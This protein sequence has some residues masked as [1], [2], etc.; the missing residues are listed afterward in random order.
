[1]PVSSSPGRPTSRSISSSG[2]R[3]EMLAVAGQREGPGGRAARTPVEGG[4]G[5]VERA[6]CPRLRSRV[7]IRVRRSGD[8]AP[9]R[10][11][12]VLRAWT[13]TRGGHPGDP[14]LGEAHR[15]ARAWHRVVGRS[16]RTRS[17]VI[18]SVVKVRAGKVTTWP[19]GVTARPARGPPETGCPPS[20]V[21]VTRVIDRSGSPVWGWIE[22]Q[23]ALG[24]GVVQ[25]DLP[26]L[27]LRGGEGVCPPRR[28]GG[29]RRW[30]RR[31]GPRA[32]R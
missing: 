11:Q 6:G 19:G 3:G 10:P 27:A 2:M 5:V 30:R 23:R 31:A 7:M 28:S 9:G 22:G 18:R 8:E 29:C 16:P 17:M 25:V 21:R 24:G 12:Q 4:L 32:G 26:P 15:A 13:M 20:K 1:M 14:H